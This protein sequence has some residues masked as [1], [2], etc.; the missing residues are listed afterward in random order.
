MTLLED[1]VHRIEHA[2]NLDRVAKPIASKVGELVKPRPVRNFLSG[3]W[4]GHPLHPLLSD[5]PI[6]AWS[7]AALLDALDVEA[8]DILV[9]AGIVAAVP[10]A[11]AGANDWSDTYGEE[12][13]LGLV[14][15][16]SNSTALVLQIASLLARRRDE[17]GL[18][19]ALS[20]AGVAAMFV[21][22]Y[23]GGHLTFVK[24]VD[25]NHTAWP[26]GPDSWTS[27]IAEAD[28]ADG[29]PTKV[30]AGGVSVLLYRHGNTIQAL[31]NTCSH[32]GGPLDEGSVSH[33]GSGDCV[34]CPWHGSTFR[35]NDGEVVRGPATIPQPR[36]E[37]R[38]TN[39]HIEV[40]VRP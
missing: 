8:A 30:D 17:R 32:M 13:R 4:L 14:H 31:A 18:G 37:T 39:G 25:V 12:T 36:Y 20:L 28:L 35:L 15:A 29:K 22:G 19:K 40:R 7:M 9:G 2:D 33:D 38:V 24:A 11:A 16:A 3:T 23:L 10:T 6:G 27:V 5:L 34:T 26:T 1:L 21:G